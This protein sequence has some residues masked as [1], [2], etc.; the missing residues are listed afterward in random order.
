[1]T[2]ISRLP[3]QLGALVTVLT[4]LS[5]PCFAQKVALDRGIKPDEEDAEVSS[6]FREMGVVQRK[7]MQKADKWLIG[8]YGSLDF[9][10]GPYSMYGLNFDVGYALSDFWEV[11]VNYVPLFL[12]TKRS[13]VDKLEEQG[14]SIS[15]SKPKYQFGG[16]VVWA[17]AYGKDSI[18][19]K[20]VIRS[21]TF[22]K[23]G[24]YNT[25]YESGN[26]MK[27]TFGV[28]KTYFLTP[29]SGFRIAA[30]AN[31][32]QTILDG[33][34]SYKFFAIVEAGLNFYL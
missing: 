9:S 19:S 3:I 29:W 20:R 31:M 15:F 6:V 1:M 5:G 13:I 32:I 24:A 22:F 16:A 10:D 18:G 25:Q 4:V 27:F 26:G 30:T 34:K 23:L 11:Y 28:G 2:R 12:S 14:L 21:D 8:S 17:P 33:T 7:A